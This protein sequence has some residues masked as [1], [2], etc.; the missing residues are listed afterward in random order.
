MD[1]IEQAEARLEQL[2]SEQRRRDAKD[3]LESSLKSGSLGADDAA[4]NG[5]RRKK[6]EAIEASVRKAEEVMRNRSG[7]EGGDA[8]M[9]ALVKE[10]QGRIQALKEE[11]E[12]MRR[13]EEERRRQEEEQEALKEAARVA[14]LTPAERRA[15]EKAVARQ[16]MDRREEDWA[17][18]KR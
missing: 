12:Q 16:T 18:Q 8:E 7:E 9:G 13:Q 14:A 11:E 5:S 4:G 10:G 1:T 2:R 3:A 15:E 6:W 17:L